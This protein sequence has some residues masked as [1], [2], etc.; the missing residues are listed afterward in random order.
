[1]SPDHANQSQYHRLQQIKDK[2]APPI[3]PNLDR[4]LWVFPGGDCFF[5]K[6]EMRVTQAPLLDF[7]ISEKKRPSSSASKKGHYFL[8]YAGSNHVQI[9][10]VPWQWREIIFSI[11]W[12]FRSCSIG[13]QRCLACAIL[14]HIQCKYSVHFIVGHRIPKMPCLCHPNSHPVASIL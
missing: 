13:C 14:T 5:P 11:M 4:N 9:S 3:I 7:F 8:N 10:K 12:Y 1:M 6:V 2:G